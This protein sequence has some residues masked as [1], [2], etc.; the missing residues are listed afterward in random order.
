MAQS[1]F[2]LPVAGLNPGHPTLTPGLA[3][4]DRQQRELAA[5]LQQAPQPAQ[6]LRRVR[7]GLQQ[8]QS[9]PRILEDLRVHNALIVLRQYAAP[10]QGRA[11]LYPAPAPHHA[12]NGPRDR[13]RTAR[14]AAP[15]PNIG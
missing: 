10:P 6:V 2:A 5:A 13:P 15:A 11:A 14:R 9:I 3:L 8:R 4:T 1:A 12:L 7:E